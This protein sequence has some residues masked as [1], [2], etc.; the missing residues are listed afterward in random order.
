MRACRLSLALALLATLF[1]SGCRTTGAGYGTLQNSADGADIRVSFDWRSTDSVSGTMTAT[2]SDGRSFTGQ[3][4]QITSDTRI[5]HLGP[6]WHEWS[7][8][9]RGWRYWYRDPG[10]QL[11]KHYSGRVLANLGSTDG[12]RM[13]C[14]FRLIRPA[15]GMSGG[16]EG[17]C[18]L[19]D[20]NTIYATFPAV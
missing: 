19:P 18:Q 4:F 8:A 13:R 15:S 14:R 11:V 7:P 10:P 16:G 1:V 9:W 20:G 5:D 2:F 17:T 12:E 3:Y 6:L